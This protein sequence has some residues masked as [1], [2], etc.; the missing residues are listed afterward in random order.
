MKQFDVIVVGGGAAGLV[1]AGKA[2]EAGAKVILLEKN[3]LLG[4]KLLITGK[5]RCNITNA[6]EIDELIEAFGSKGSF[7]YSAFYTFSNLDTINFFKRLGL[8]TMTERGNRV[9]PES[10]QAK[11][12]ADALKDYVQRNKATISLESPVEEILINP[13]HQ[14]IG[15]RLTSGQ[16]VMGKKIIMA[17]GGASYPGTGSTGDGYKILSNLGHK[18][19]PIKPALVPLETEEKWVGDLQGLGLKNV[20]LSVVEKGKKTVQL[21]GEMLFT[22]FGISGPIVL[23]ISKDIARILE[24]TGKP[25]SVSIDLKPAL[26]DEKLDLRIQRDFTKYA[27]KIIANSLGD[28]LPR[29]L[30]PIILM[31]AKLDGEKFVHQ[32][33]REERKLLVAALKNLSLTVTKTRPLKEAIVTAGGVDLKEINP[34]TMESKKI[35][36]LFVVGELLDIDGITGGFN[37]QA[38]FSTGFIAGM[39]AANLQET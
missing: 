32:I 13:Q 38:A 22:H 10:E 35:Q 26:S 8:R 30:I 34:G 16:Q 9:F 7:L 21:F 15:V 11:D 36:G 23:T 39:N 27:K 19:I 28:L 4:K 29:T 33:S 2:A 20:E 14:V 12:V 37:L 17:M 25:V 31:A 5:G 6:G 24:K 1:A 18:I 3:S